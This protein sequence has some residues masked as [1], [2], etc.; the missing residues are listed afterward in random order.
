LSQLSSMLLLTCR[1]SRMFKTIFKINVIRALSLLKQ[2]HSSE[3]SLDRSLDHVIRLSS[4]AAQ[5][6]PMRC[7]HSDL[8]PTLQSNENSLEKCP[9]SIF[10]LH[11]PVE[12]SDQAFKTSTSIW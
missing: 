6:I 1:L 7:P 4:V 11:C 5:S 10:E 8:C 12:L 3:F 2:H 9:M